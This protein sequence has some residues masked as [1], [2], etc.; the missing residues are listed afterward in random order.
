MARP[1]V[2]SQLIAGDPKRGIA[3]CATCHG[4]GGYRLGAP[5]LARQNAEYI[6]QQLQNFAQAVRRNDM[7]MPMRTI[8]PLIKPDEIHA[9]ALAYANGTV[10]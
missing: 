1:G 8:A 5:T 2:F 3:G 4:P 6:E 9:L 7:N 10:E